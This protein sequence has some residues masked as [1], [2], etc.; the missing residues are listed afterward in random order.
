M[1]RAL[2]DRISPGIAPRVTGRYRLGDVRHVHCSPA[3]AARE[4]GFHVRVGFAEGMDEFARAP[5][6]A[7]VP[8]GVGEAA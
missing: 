1:A 2:A 6:R 3:L 4:L 7:P 5:L 8:A